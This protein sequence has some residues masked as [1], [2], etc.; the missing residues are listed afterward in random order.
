[1]QLDCRQRT[2]HR[3]SAASSFHPAQDRW[4]PRCTDTADRQICY[5]HKLYVSAAGPNSQLTVGLQA[6]AA[7]R[8]QQAGLCVA[9]PCC[10]WSAAKALLESGLVARA[11]ARKGRHA[12]GAGRACC[13]S[14]QL[15]PGRSGAAA[16]CASTPALQ[17]TSH[18]VHHISILASFAEHECCCSGELRVNTSPAGD[19][20]SG[21]P[22]CHLQMSHLILQPRPG[23]HRAAASCA[24]TPAQQATSHQAR[25]CRTRT[26]ITLTCRALMLLRWRQAARQHQP[27]RR[28]AIRSGISFTELRFAQRSQAGTEA[29]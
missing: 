20:P 6:A 29:S 26:D 15:R 21:A 2:Q 13:T 25:P 16:R 11:Q 23:R 19:K 18:Q 5:R 14:L 27:C 8:S 10:R 17:A 22:F 12:D 24:S 7:A 1:M 4:L 3:S 9:V 28:R